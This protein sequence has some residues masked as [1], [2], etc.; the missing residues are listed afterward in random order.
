MKVKS[1]FKRRIAKRQE[2]SGAFKLPKSGINSLKEI[3]LSIQSHTQM[4]LNSIYTS[5]SLKQ[6]DLMIKELASIKINTIPSWNSPVE[7]E[8]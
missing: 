4:E 3:V 5:L 1:T 6:N 8:I 2:G 7:A